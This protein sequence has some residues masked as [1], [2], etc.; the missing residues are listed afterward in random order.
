MSA[1]QDKKK[2]TQQRAEGTERRQVASQKA[3][4]EKKKSRIKWIVGSILVV[5]LIGFII[6]GNSNL[7]YTAQK[8]VTIN[9]HSYS[10][11]EFNYEYMSTYQRYN[12]MYTQY[13]GDA[14]MCAP[15]ALYSEDDED[16][17]AFETWGDFYKDAAIQS[18]ATKQA[19]VDMAEADGVTLTEEEIKEIDDS[20]DELAS[21]AKEY[22]YGSASKFL[23]ANYGQGVT[24]K[25]ARELMLRDA[26]ADKYQTQYQENLSFSDDELQAAYAEHKDEYDAYTFS[27]Y[28]VQA[29][30]ETV[31]AEDGTETAAEPTD[32]AM[33]AAKELADKLVSETKGDAERFAAVVADNCPAQEQTQMDDSGSVV[34]DEEGNPVT[35]LKPAEPARSEATQGST[36]VNYGMPFSDWVMEADRQPGDMTVVEQEGTGYYVVIFESRDDNSYSTVNVRHILIQAEDADEDGAYSDEELAAAKAEIEKVQA[37]YEAGAQ[38]EDAFAELAKQYSTDPGSK[39]NGGLYEN[40][41]RG[42]MVQEFNDWC[43]DET[44]QPGDVGI[45]EDSAYN[46]CHL[47]YFVGAGDSYQTVLARNALS[48]EAMSTFTDGLTADLQVKELFAMRYAGVK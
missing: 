5:L 22:G 26:L 8:A 28:L 3:A 34:T 15:S 1:S 19:L 20:L 48:S 37:E 9:G 21:A 4:Q 27:Y 12:Q 6:V 25:L 36:L 17:D 10:V 30:T 35:E 13:M 31:T 38:T 41:Y 29:E 2:R 40:V 23:S 7:F 42:Q 33:A 47:M 45:I 43:Y 24:V 39:D 14:S 46:G 11:A 32:E 16:G 44:R 18:L